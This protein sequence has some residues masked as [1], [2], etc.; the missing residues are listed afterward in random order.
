ML[1][2]SATPL[3]KIRPFLALW[4]GQLISSLGDHLLHINAVAFVLSANRAAGGAMAQVLIWAT[5]PTLLVGLVAGVV[6]DR[7]NRKSLMMA[8]DLIRAALIALLPLAA[9]HGFGWVCF[10]IALV[11][12]ASAFF[13]P[14]KTALIPTVVSPAQ[15]VAA[16]AWF[17]ASGFVTALAGTVIGSWV[18][19]VFGASVGLWMNAAVFACSA[20]AISA[21]RIQ[22]VTRAPARAPGLRETLGELRVGW[23]FIVR[24]RIVRAFTWH[25]A[26]LMGMTAAVYVG[27]VGLA[28]RHGDRALVGISCLLSAAVAGLIIGGILAH[29]LSR[30]TPIRRLIMVALACV[31]VGALGVALNHEFAALMGCLAAIG[32]G[33]AMYAAVIEAGLQRVAPDAVRGRII[34]TRGVAGGIAVLVGSAG[35]GWLIDHASQS[36]LFGS[37]ASLCLIGIIVMAVVRPPGLLFRSTRWILRQLGFAYFRLSVSGLQHIPAQG[38]AII[39]GNHP[40]VLDGI[41]LL[42]ASPRPVRFLVTEE[43]FFHPYLHWLFCA[44]GCIPVYRTRAHNGDALRAAVAA[45]NRGEVVG[46]FPEGTTS[47]LGR[48][49]AIKLGVILLALRTGAPVVPLGIWGSAEA[50]PQGSRVPRPRPIALSFAPAVRYAKALAEIIP[51]ELLDRT[52]EDIYLEMVRAMRWSMAAL[53]LD[54]RAQQWRAIRVALSA[55]VVLPLASFLQMTSRPSLEPD[56]SKPA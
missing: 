40:N 6:V 23:R 51:N 38:A 55:V 15:L 49:R 43:L 46:I 52:Q 47:D 32:A 20:L 16:N 1:T 36:L 27:V 35:A 13:A 42:I 44:M 22:T 33:A 10:V 2:T 9:Q 19:A 53:E 39:A 56:R 41:L 45:L 12:C 28:N 7:V 3:L 29:R 17:S 25:Y 4:L 31:G 5:A 18:L 26:F 24:S 54:R 48:L 34:A 14:A 11:A 37:V 30:R 21:A 8:S 50:Y